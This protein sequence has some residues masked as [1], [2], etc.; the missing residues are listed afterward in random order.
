MRRDKKHRVLKANEYQRSDGRYVYNYF[1][2]DK[3]K[4]LYSW[5]LVETDI[6]PAGKKKG[7]ALRTLEAELEQKLALGLV[8]DA[9][10]ITVKELLD[11]FIKYRS[12]GLRAS[13]MRGYDSERIVSPKQVFIICVFRILLFCNA[14]AGFMN[15]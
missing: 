7:K 6:P 15:W 11:L 14:K 3:K 5:T 13:T 9:E 4:Y 8:P 1:E 10:T 12:K 2:N